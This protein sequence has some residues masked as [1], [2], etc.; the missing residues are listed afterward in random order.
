MLNKKLSRVLLG[1]LIF[2]GVINANSFSQVLPPENIAFSSQLASPTDTHCIYKPGDF[3][4]DGKVSL[5]DL[6]NLAECILKNFCCGAIGPYCLC[7]VNGNGGA[8]LADVVYLVNYLFK[9]GPAPVNS[10]VCCL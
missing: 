4:R 1:L 3:N 6:V 5:A 7:D 2:L 10:D 8:N 9:G